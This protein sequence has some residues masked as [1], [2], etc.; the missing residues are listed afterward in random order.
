MS[1]R[2]APCEITEI[3][4]QVILSVRAERASTS[5]CSILETPDLCLLLP[6][7]VLLDHLCLLIA[8]LVVVPIQ[9]EP[10]VFGEAN[11]ALRPYAAH[12]DGNNRAKKDKDRLPL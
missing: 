4:L 12:Q 7:Y 1:P 11:D 10:V 6:I 5:S 9:T 8:F 2:E 3:L